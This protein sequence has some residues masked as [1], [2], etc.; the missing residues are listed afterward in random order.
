MP[1]QALAS[2]AA[3]ELQAAV[4]EDGG[5]DEEQDAAG[6]PDAQ[7]QLFLGVA[8]RCRVSFQ[9]VKNSTLVC[10]GVGG[11]AGHTHDVRCQ[12][13]QVFNKEGGAAGRHP[14]LLLE[15]FS[16]VTRQHAVPVGVVHDAVKAVG[17]TG[18]F[19]PNHQCR[20]S[21][22]VLDDYSHRDVA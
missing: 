20:V 13:S 3:Q 7:R 1:L 16:R 2:P 5:D 21:C 15:A 17:T 9:R 8:R 11:L 4:E 10:G 6:E 12:R 14:L 22:D 18:H 19:W